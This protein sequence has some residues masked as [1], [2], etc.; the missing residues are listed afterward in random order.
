MNDSIEFNW[1]NIYGWW[2]YFVEFNPELKDPMNFTIRAVPDKPEYKYGY[3]YISNWVENN[4]KSSLTK[5]DGEMIK[6]AMNDA[7]FRWSAGEIHTAFLLTRCQTDEERAAV[8]ISAFANTF[9]HNN[10]GNN[11]TYNILEKIRDKS[12]AIF[13]GLYG[14][15]KEKS[16]SFFPKFFFPHYVINEERELS[17]VSLVEMAVAN[18]ALV[19]NHFTPITFDR[20]LVA[21]KE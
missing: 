1:E 21:S 5:T 9:V 11:A 18:A 13:T 16:S 17:Y 4:T 8:W 10:K 6:D 7:A 20:M 19:L 12:L 14:N 15:W 2:S 3:R